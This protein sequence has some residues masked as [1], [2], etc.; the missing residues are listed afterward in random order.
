[1]YALASQDSRRDPLCHQVYAGSTGSPSAYTSAARL[2]ADH[3]LGQ[4]A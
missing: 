4:P 1:M 3:A 2:N